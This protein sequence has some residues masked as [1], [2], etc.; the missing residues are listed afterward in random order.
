MQF[1]LS[2]H[3]V[4]LKK[5][6]FHFISIF[7]RLRLKCDDTRPETR[8]RLSTKRT[9]P[10]KLAGASLQS[11]AV[12]RGVRISGSNAGYNKFRGSVKGTG[13][14]LHSLVSY[15]LP[16]PCVTVR[17]HASTGFYL[18]HMSIASN[19]TNFSSQ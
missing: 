15:S 1:N 8:F 5:Q 3:T 6:T 4:K 10:F 13:Y 7:G 12:S 16:I 11:T 14:T 17:H 18:I 2:V 19:H 9:S